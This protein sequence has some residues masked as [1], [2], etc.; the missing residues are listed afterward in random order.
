[1]GERLAAEHERAIREAVARGEAAGDNRLLH[2]HVGR[3]L[4]AELA[5]LRADLARVTG[6][7]DEWSRAL[8][9][10][11]VAI[12]GQVLAEKERDDE[13]AK[14]NEW[15]AQAHDAR[16]Q[17]AALHAAAENRD[18]CAELC[19]TMQPYRGCTCGDHRLRAALTDTA[20]AAKAHDEETAARAVAGVTDQL[21]T[22]VWERLG[23]EPVMPIADL[24]TTLGRR[25]HERGVECEKRLGE[26]REQCDTL[27]SALAEVR[28]K[29]TPLLDPRQVDGYALERAALRDALSALPVDLAAQHDARVRAEALRALIP[30]YD[31][32]SDVD[33]TEWLADEAERGGR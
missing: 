9:D 31:V 19:L 13:R 1:M 29:A 18:S 30:P 27:A 3:D 11:N 8:L 28:E 32:M 12:A 4:L 10:R 25:L 33:I 17:L 22:I 21:S 7:R 20:A 24:L 15:L 26:M 5:A 16:A 23:P 14:A 2:W 6:E